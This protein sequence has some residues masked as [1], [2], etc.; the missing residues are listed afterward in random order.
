M[1][2]HIG[3][4]VQRLNLIYINKSRCFFFNLII[5]YKIIFGFLKGITIIFI[6]LFYINCERIKNIFKNWFLIL[7]SIIVLLMYS[8]ILIEYRYISVFI[9]LLWLGLFSSIAI[10]SKENSKQIFRCSIL[11]IATLMCIKFGIMGYHYLIEGYSPS[12]Q[13]D[14]SK[15]QEVVYELKKLG[16]TKGDKVVSF[17]DENVQYWARIG[18]FKVVAEIPPEE[19]T[20]YIRE[21][22]SILN[23][24]IIRILKK[25]DAKA[26]VTVNIANFI[27]PQAEKNGWKKLGDTNDL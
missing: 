22:K 25:T 16:L 12:T 11:T 6:F 3:L 19:R 7:P 24:T 1:I 15:M 2:I 10:S 14:A 5:C 26:I 13:N 4:M 21:T 23:P 17:F 8:L 27:R 20:G 18:R 9:L